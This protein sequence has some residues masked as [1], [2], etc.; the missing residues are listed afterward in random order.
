MVA[1]RL[2]PAW[3][4]LRLLV[5]ARRTSLWAELKPLLRNGLISMLRPG[6]WSAAQVKPETGDIKPNL[7]PPALFQM[8]TGYWLSQAIYVAA[9]LGLA[10]LLKD[11]PKSCATLAAATGADE[12]SLLRLMR[13][14]SS[15]GVFVRLKDYQFA[16]ST[17]GE[18][19]Q[20][21][22]PG[23]LRAMVMTIG[24]I[25]YQAWGNLLHSV[26]SG[27]PAFAKTFGTGLFDY[28]QHNPESADTFNNGMTDLASMLAYA[29]LMAYDF[30]GISSI[31]DIGGGQG[32]FL[33]TVLEL[34]PEMKGTV[35]DTQSTTERAKHCI[36]GNNCGGRYSTISGNFFDSV[37]EGADAYVLCGVIHD[38]D[39][40]YS[41][42]I[43]KNCRKAMMTHGR[44][45]LV[46]MVVPEKDANCFS[47]L[48]DLN[49]LVM[50]GGRERTQSEFCA[51][52]DAAD[53][54][55]T[56]V[57]PTLAPQSVIEAI[58][59]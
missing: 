28:L 18:S 21:N 8:V 5:R 3:P 58:P 7:Q 14:L 32:R 33:R 26:H 31:I 40:D 27:S 52:L 57:V 53:Y 11:G 9:K 12:Q 47:S 49:M 38:W 59:R 37:P 45:L 4:L 16:T 13:A 34:N 20:S 23:S 55:L 48:L 39:N 42:K 36:R 2:L 19:L 51:L 56:K 54:K 17:V 24:E 25:H 41:I 6:D 43:L 15:A 1:R 29:V 30:S 46:E 22:V 50:T 44:L 35:F 10:D